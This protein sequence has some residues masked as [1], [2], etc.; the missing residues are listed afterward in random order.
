METEMARRAEMA[1][2]MTKPTEL[3]TELSPVRIRR[4]LLHLSEFW[5]AQR[6]PASVLDKLIR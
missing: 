6:L 5:S 4:A 3:V 1:T 2:A